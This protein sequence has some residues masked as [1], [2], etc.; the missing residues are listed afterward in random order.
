MGWW[1]VPVPE[2]GEA[3]DSAIEA[4]AGRRAAP[5]THDAART[6]LRDAY[7]AFQRDVHS[8][9]LHAARDPDV[10]ADVTQDAFVRLL[11]EAQRNGPP[12]HIKPWLIRVAA[13]LIN[14]RGRRISVANRFVQRFGRRDETVESPEVGILREEHRGE[15]AAM[16]GA[17][18][19]DARTCL[20]MAAEGFTGREIAEAIGRT[21]LATRVLMSRA[22]NRLR[23]TIE[24][25]A[26]VG[27]SPDV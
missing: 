14:S 2:P 17:I 7:E 1:V 27:R 15:V 13:N 22:R 23:E 26:D 25:K 18:P 10:A 3:D 12:E 20:L 21:E 8:F 9:A 16:L 19:P 4:A 11:A 5:L 24:A 6:F